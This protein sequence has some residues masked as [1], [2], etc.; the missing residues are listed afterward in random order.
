[1]IN[2]SLLPVAAPIALGSVNLKNKLNQPLDVGGQAIFVCKTGTAT[3]AYNYKKYTLQAGSIFIAF[4]DVS[5][6]PFDVSVDFS[7]FVLAVSDQAARS[8]AYQDEYGLFDFL[9]QYPVFVLTAEQRKLVSSWQHMVEWA[10]TLGSDSSTDQ[11]LF[12]AM[13][14]FFLALEVEVKKRYPLTKRGVEHSRSGGMVNQLIRLIL[15]HVREN[16]SLSF[17][18]DKLNVTP[19]YLNKIMQKEYHRSPKAVIDCF[20]LAE[21]KALLSTTDLSMKEIASEMNFDDPAY[22]NRFFSRHTGISLTKFR[23]GIRQQAV[24][25]SQTPYATCPSYR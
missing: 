2:Y 1:M 4:G 15:E 10:L 14:S 5:F 13:T 9:H 8:V 22:L 6:I 25:S 16:N 19:G 17:Y 12:N 3:I 7:V 20:V 23:S 21:V 18:A 24:K 11:L